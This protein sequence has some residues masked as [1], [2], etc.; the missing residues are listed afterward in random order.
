MPKKWT[1]RKQV[2]PGRYIVTIEMHGKRY[3]TIRYFD[4]EKGWTTKNGVK[5]RGVVAYRAVPEPF[6]G[7]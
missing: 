7:E 3:T 6:K 2:A 5:V 1:T 4:W